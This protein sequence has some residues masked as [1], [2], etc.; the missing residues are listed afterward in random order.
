[1]R[2]FLPDLTLPT[3]GSS[4]SVSPSNFPGVTNLKLSLHRSLPA[5]LKDTTNQPVRTNRFAAPV[6]SPKQ[7]K[8][9]KGM[10]LANTESNTQWVV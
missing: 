8:A 9:A 6:T 5:P 1:M 4:R 2:D 10:I 3:D 7:E